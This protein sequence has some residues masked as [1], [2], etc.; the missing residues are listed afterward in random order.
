[1]LNRDI[2]VDKLIDEHSCSFS[3]EFADFLF[4]EIDKNFLFQELCT[5]FYLKEEI[6]KCEPYDNWSAEDQLEHYIN[7]N[8]FNPIEKFQEQTSKVL[9][10]LS[11]YI[12]V[13]NIISTK[14][15]DLKKAAI[16]SVLFQEEVNKSDLNY[17]KLIN[18]FLADIYFYN[19]KRTK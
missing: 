1:M 17:K 15:F 13:D 10:I 2:I 4:Q 11:N 18:N 14:E 19:M 6:K 7:L 5:F 12:S 16:D 3:E 8:G 9:N